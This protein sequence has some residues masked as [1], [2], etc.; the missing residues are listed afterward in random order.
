MSASLSFSCPSADAISF[1]N[2]FRD[3]RVAR[4]TMAQY[5]GGIVGSEVRGLDCSGM[6]RAMFCQREA[7]LHP[8]VGGW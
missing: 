2:R 4:S 8:M 1:A 3:F 7:L 6:V 5:P